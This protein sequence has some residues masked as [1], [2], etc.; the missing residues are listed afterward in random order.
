MRSRFDRLEA[1][2]REA[3]DQVHRQYRRDLVLYRQESPFPA[4]KG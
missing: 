3:I 1:E 4:R 2:M